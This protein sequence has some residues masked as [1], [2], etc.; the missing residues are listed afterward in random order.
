MP[1]GTAPVLP[2]PPCRRHPVQAEFPGGD[3]T[4]DGG[5]RL[6]R[7]VDKRLGWLAAVDRVLPEPRDPRLMAPSPL[8]L[9]RQRG[10]GLCLGD[11]DRN[12]HPTLRTAVALQTA[13]VRTVTLASAATRCRREP[14][15][16]RSVR[17]RLPEGVVEQFI[18]AF[19]PPPTELILDVE[20]SDDPVH[21]RQEQRFVHGADDQIS[22]GG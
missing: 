14:R 15:A 19:D 11:E 5:V 21:G 7:Q 10:Y 6:L 12:E 2:F 8:S 18:A 9:V 4:R 22:G 17:W 1:K 20:A 16:D 13:L 3:I